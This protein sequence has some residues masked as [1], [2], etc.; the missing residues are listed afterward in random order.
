MVPTTILSYKA[1]LNRLDVLGFNYVHQGMKINTKLPE[2]IRSLQAYDAGKSVV[3]RQVNE[4]SAAVL[5]PRSGAVLCTI[6][7]DLHHFDEN[8]CLVPVV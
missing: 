3:V 6:T 7:M 2:R 8:G 1:A 5:N 4:R